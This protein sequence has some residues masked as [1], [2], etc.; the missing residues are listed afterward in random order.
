MTAKARAA[1]ICKGEFVLVDEERAPQRSR[2]TGR[3][4]LTRSRLT[5]RRK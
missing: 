2:L 1:E 4:A 5:R 3:K